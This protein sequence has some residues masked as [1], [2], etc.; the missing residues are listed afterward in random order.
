MIFAEMVLQ[1]PDRIHGPFDVDQRVTSGD[2]R[3]GRI[4]GLG[5]FDD[6]GFVAGAELVGIDHILPFLGEADG[7]VVTAGVTPSGNEQNHLSAFHTMF[8]T[9][10]QRSIVHGTAVHPFE[11]HRRVIYATRY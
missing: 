7:A 8:A 9:F 1:H 3:T 6:L 2:A 4:H 11:F 10:G 5:L